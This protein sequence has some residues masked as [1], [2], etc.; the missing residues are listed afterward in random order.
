MDWEVHISWA[1]FQCQVLAWPTWAHS[2]FVRC[3]SQT[4]GGA[5]VAEQSFLSFPHPLKAKKNVE[6]L[7]LVALLHYI[8][9]KIALYWKCKSLTTVRVVLARPWSW[10][11]HLK[12]DLC[13][14]FFLN[15]LCV[16][17]CFVFSTQGK[18]QKVPSMTPGPCGFLWLFYFLLFQ[19]N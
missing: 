9:E 18:T 15:I 12:H 7:C 11:C 6:L 14:P 10:I 4:C 1:S 19:S 13:S 2:Q 3:R 17:F 16:C 8:A 5:T